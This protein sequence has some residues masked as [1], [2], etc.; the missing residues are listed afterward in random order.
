MNGKVL[1]KELRIKNL[2]M[3][4]KK[5]ILF[6]NEKIKNH[7]L[8]IF[9]T[10]CDPEVP[11]LSV[12][13]LGIIRNI[14]V[15]NDNVEVTITPTYTGCPAM[16]VIRLNIRLALLEHGYNNIQIKTVLSPA[17]TTDWMSEK[18]KEKLKNYGIA[19]PQ[20]VCTLD[21][22][23]EEIH[24]LAVSSAVAGAFGG[25]QRLVNVAHKV[26]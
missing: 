15:A 21:A 3:K 11:V 8:D 19:P 7:I 12:I 9:E 24:A 23:Q 20:S 22:F 10:V 4:E 26:H 16:D 13:D 17:W 18:G 1:N 2:E 14:E 25:V 5:A 6:A